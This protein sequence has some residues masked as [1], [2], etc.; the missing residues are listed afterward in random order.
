MAGKWATQSGA[1]V[2]YIAACQSI[3]LPTF[4]KRICHRVL[5][6]NVEESTAVHPRRSANQGLFDKAVVSAKLDSEFSV[7]E[8]SL[9]FV[10][11]YESFWRYH[12]RFQ[13]MGW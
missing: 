6:S 8:E 1:M 13:S 5:G 4:L 3:I 12:F 11:R 7:V 9:C 2:R 10:A